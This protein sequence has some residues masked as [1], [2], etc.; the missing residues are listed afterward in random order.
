MN[1]S[2]SVKPPDSSKAAFLPFLPEFRAAVLEGR[3]T[4]TCRSKPYGNACDVVGTPFGPVRFTMII[5]VPLGL[6]GR[7]LFASEGLRSPMEFVE[8]WNRIHP[9]AGYDQN[10][11][12]WLHEFEVV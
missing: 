10:R 6:V 8:V 2:P 12:V 3:K 9:R 11:L 1:P 4:L 7:H 5:Q